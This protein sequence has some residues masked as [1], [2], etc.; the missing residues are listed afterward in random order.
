MCKRQEPHT[1]GNVPS[2]AMA[3]SHKKGQGV[4]KIFSFGR[5]Q[6]KGGRVGVGRESALPATE[7]GEEGGMQMRHAAPIQSHA[8][9]SPV[10][11]LQTSRPCLFVFMSQNC[12]SCLFNRK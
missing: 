3:G 7:E 1:P 2:A 10:S 5:L 6:P 8:T 4:F 12:L 9:W 11:K